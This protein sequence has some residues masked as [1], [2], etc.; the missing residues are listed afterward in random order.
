M[1]NGQQ[2]SIMCIWCCQVCIYGVLDGCKSSEFCA[3]LST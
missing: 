1:K 3:D 2:N